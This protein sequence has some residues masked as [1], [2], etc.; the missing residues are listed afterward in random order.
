MMVVVE[1][2]VRWFCDTEQGTRYA[3]F[4]ELELEVPNIKYCL[5]TFPLRECWKSEVF[6]SR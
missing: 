5:K 6:D 3:Y 1:K 2:A 4:D